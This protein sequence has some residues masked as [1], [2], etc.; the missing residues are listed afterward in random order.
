M[1]KVPMNY[2][3]GTGVCCCTAEAHGKHYRWQ[4]FPV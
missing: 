1:K 3:S 4:H 2:Y